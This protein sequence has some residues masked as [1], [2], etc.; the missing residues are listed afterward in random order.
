MRP[1]VG[2]FTMVVGLTVHFAY[3]VSNINVN[4]HNYE[5]HL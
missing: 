1:L 2:L 3:S 4:K 5:T